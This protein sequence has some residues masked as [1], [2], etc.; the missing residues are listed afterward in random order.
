MESEKNLRN[1][2]ETYQAR[3]KW[4]YDAAVQAQNQVN[5]INGEISDTQSRIQAVVNFENGTLT[6]LETTNNTLTDDLKNMGKAVSAGLADE[7][8]GSGA[9]NLNKNNGAQL[10]IVRDKCNAIITRLNRDLVSLNGSLTKAQAD[11]DRENAAVKSNQRLQQQVDNE[12]RQNY[13]Q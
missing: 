6:G 1:E 7:N 4:H 3:A 11:L 9:K 2:S 12:L 8:A 13:P 5:A 10:K